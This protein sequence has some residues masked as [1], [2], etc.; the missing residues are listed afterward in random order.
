MELSNQINEII[1]NSKA[2][3][4]EVEEDKRVLNLKED[5]SNAA[6]KAIDHA[7]KYIIKAMPIP[8]AVKDILIDIKESLK[9]K[10]FKEII[11]TAVKSTVR[12]GLETIGVNDRNINSLMELNEIA[13]KGG[14]ITALKNGVEIIS[15]N[16]LRNNIV[17]D[18]VYNFFNKLKNYI[19]NNEFSRSL[20]R[21]IK[22]MEEKKEK[23]LKRC[24]EWHEAYKSENLDK[25]NTIAAQ[26]N[27]NNYILD[28]YSDCAKENNVI[29]N[30]TDMVNN[31]NKMLTNNQQ[32]LCE[33]I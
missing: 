2:L 22:N 33:V 13:K 1:E 20:S 29:Q 16:Y 21:F 25:I 26:L 3:M 12:E 30:M 11:S 28:R 32:R 8:D 24:E 27:K 31:T 23:F 4:R 9:T 6:E 5:L 19:M 15:E 18:Y 7:S 14:L 17:G 10:N